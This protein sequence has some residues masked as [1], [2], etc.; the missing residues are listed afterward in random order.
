MSISGNRF[1]IAK[2]LAGLLIAGSFW[3]CNGSQENREVKLPYIR[4]AFEKEING[5]YTNLYVLRNKTGMVLALSDY[6]ARIV[7]LYAPYKD[8]KLENVVLGCPSI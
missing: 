3:N 7:S 8:G 4:E 6:G 1:G 2:I 5:E